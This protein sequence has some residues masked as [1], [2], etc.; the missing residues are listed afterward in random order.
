MVSRV[1]GA[2]LAYRGRRR[3]GRGVLRRGRYGRA[4]SG[5]GLGRLYLP[6]VVVFLRG[7][8]VLPRVR[9]VGVLALFYGAEDAC[10]VPLCELDLFLGV[11]IGRAPDAGELEEGGRRVECVGGL[12]RWDTLAYRV[13]RGV[14]VEEHTG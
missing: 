8:L 3:E 14:S 11:L 4:P 12:S 9:L 5:G 2:R 1:G 13:W 7:R 6:D 10:G